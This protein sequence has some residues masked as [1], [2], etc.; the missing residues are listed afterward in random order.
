MQFVSLA[1][2]GWSIKL[3]KIYSEKIF[4]YKVINLFTRESALGISY[5]YLDRSIAPA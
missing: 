1:K 2:K 5:N 4:K 3:F